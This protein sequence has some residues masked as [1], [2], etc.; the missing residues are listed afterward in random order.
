MISTKRNTARTDF[1]EFIKTLPDQ[2]QGNVIAYDNIPWQ[3][4]VTKNLTAEQADMIAAD[5]RA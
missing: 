1:D 5:Y 3:S 4:Y 2:G